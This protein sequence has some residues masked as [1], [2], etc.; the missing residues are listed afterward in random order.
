MN[1]G[2]KLMKIFKFS[3]WL[4]LLIGAGLFV[5]ENWDAYQSKE[6]S[7]INSKEVVD[8]FDNPTITYC[9]NPMAKG[10]VMA[11]YQVKEGDFIN[12]DIGNDTVTNVEFSRSWPEIYHES[13]Y[14]LGQDFIFK[15]Q[16][17]Q[18][19]DADKT[20]I[21]KDNTT[22]L[23]KIEEVYTLWSGLCT[24]IEIKS[25]LFPDIGNRVS[26][27]FNEA[28]PEKDIPEVGIY[29]SS[30]E[31]ASKTIQNLQILVLNF[32]L[33]YSFSFSWYHRYR[34]GQWGNNQILYK[35]KSKLAQCGHKA[36]KS[37]GTSN[38]IRM[39]KPREESL[40]VLEVMLANS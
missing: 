11:K 17:N 38:E 23:A 10:T 8:A 27:E 29:F 20:F 37:R 13:S 9:F 40:S 28:L 39:F 16:F 1:P 21:V 26:L 18:G 35:T 24:T 3:G 25:K 34:L 5:K 31:N 33:H 6:T 14:R 2:I 30:N 19:E 36:C 12:A 15:I 22:R 32:Q 4:G 7:I